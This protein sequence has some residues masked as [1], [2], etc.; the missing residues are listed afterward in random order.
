MAV[1]TGLMELLVLRILSAEDKQK[2]MHVA[3]PMGTNNMLMANDALPF[4]GESYIW[5]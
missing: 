2:I 5:Q 1:F 4:M 3:L